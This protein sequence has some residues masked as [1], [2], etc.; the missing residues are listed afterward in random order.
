MLHEFKILSWSGRQ[1]PH[2]ARSAFELIA[3]I[4][5]T[6]P[7]ALKSSPYPRFVSEFLYYMIGNAPAFIK[8]E[9][10]MYDLSLLVIPCIAWGN[11]ELIFRIPNTQNLPAI[12]DS[13]LTSEAPT[14][15]EKD[16]RILLETF[17]SLYNMK[18]CKDLSDEK[19]YP[20]TKAI[21]A[22]NFSQ[23]FEQL[24]EE[25]KIGFRKRIPI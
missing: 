21:I 9:N 14:A 11:S 5:K 22:Y 23:M 19:R 16:G 17:H 7:N 2:A 4:L 15:S 13:F 6:V 12:L 18:P 8:G 3:E 24:S 20:I 25:E 1:N 10:T